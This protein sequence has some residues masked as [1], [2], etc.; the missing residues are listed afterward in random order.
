MTEPTGPYAHAW[1]D[2]R[3]AG[4]TGVIPL[5]ARKKQH[6][7]RGVTGEAGIYPSTA[8][9]MAWADGPEGDGNIALRLPHHVLGLDVDAYDTKPGAHTLTAAEIRYGPLP[10]TWVSSSRGPGLSGIRF[11]RV[12]EGLAWPGELG[13][14]VETVHA[15]HRYAVVAPSI[16]PDGGTYQWHDPDGAPCGPPDVDQLPHLPNAWV[17]GLTGGHDAAPAGPRADFTTGQ[18]RAWLLS[19]PRVLGAPCHRTGRATT[20]ALLALAAGASAHATT[21]AAVMRIVRLADEGHAGAISALTGLHDAF[22]GNVTNPHRA[23]AVRTLGQAANEW[24]KILDSAAGKVAATTTGLDACDCDGRLTQAIVQAATPPGGASAHTPQPSPTQPSPAL[25]TPQPDP[26]A[27]PPAPNLTDPAVE[28]QIRTETLKTLIREEARR[29]ARRQQHGAQQPPSP[30]LLTDFLA[31]PDQPQQYRIEGLW[32]VGGRIMLTAQFKSGKT[33]LVGNLLR[34][35]ADGQPFLERFLT[36]TPKGRTTVIDTELDDRMLRRWLRDQRITNTGDVAVIPLRGKVSTLD[37]LD[38]QI[39]AEWA[40][41][42]QQIGTEILIVDCLAPILDALG[43]S[44]D[45]EAGQF[46]VALDELANQAGISEVVLVH[47]MGHNSERARGASRLRDWPDVEWKLA[48]EKGEENEDNPAARRFFS[49]YG[50]DVDIA[51]AALDYLPESRRL[52]LAGGSRKQAADTE[53]RDAVIA[54]LRANPGA[55]GRQVELFAGPPQK[56]TRAALKAL[57]ADGTVTAVSHSGAIIYSVAAVSISVAECSPQVSAPENGPEGPFGNDQ[58]S[59]SV[60]DAPE[61]APFGK[62]PAEL[63][64]CETAGQSAGGEPFGKL[65]NHSAT[66]RQNGGEALGNRAPL[67]GGA[68]KLPSSATSATQPP[69][70]QKPDPVAER[71]DRVRKDRL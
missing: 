12:P 42:L 63:A 19:K 20:D 7:P 2:Y 9:C 39:R 65:G 44:E 30:V 23:G 27:T 15:R 55:V 48:R 53:F 5:P 17:E 58:L 32:P 70:D 31:Q 24:R 8:D 34:S 49:A 46:L 28:D 18:A 1:Q 64:E 40:A 71:L 47:H 37:L 4:W 61:A 6:P 62:P 56:K 11:Y 22:T 13:P 26:Y 57:V 10:A 25:H 36:H 29:R 45:K 51:E 52:V 33:T 66:T 60:P 54:Y 59:I 41:R 50:R 3:A 68:R 38:E 35:L 14:A 69:Q 16:H 67:R 21:T 43:L